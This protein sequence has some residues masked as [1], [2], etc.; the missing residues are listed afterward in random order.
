MMNYEECPEWVE[1]G[2]YHE[3]PA[4][5]RHWM[6]TGPGTRPHEIAQGEDLCIS[7]SDE[8]A[9]NFALQLPEVQ[10]LV[11][12]LRKLEAEQMGGSLSLFG[13]SYCGNT[14]TELPI[15]HDARCPFAT[16]SLLADLAQHPDQG[17]IRELLQAQGDLDEMRVRL[18][19]LHPHPYQEDHQ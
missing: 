18:S 6:D 12:A 1:L 4:V 13:C 8:E 17:D 5:Y 16:L 11:V 14:A 19:A 3:V 2:T 9:R 10:A 15:K 7:L